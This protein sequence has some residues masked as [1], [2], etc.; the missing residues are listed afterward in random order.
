MTRKPG[1]LW[2]IDDHGVIQNDA[3]REYLQPPFSALIDNAVRAYVDHIGSDLDSIYVTGS[4][5]RGLAIEGQSDLNMFAVTDDNVDPDLVM[6]DWIKSAEADLI[7]KHP[8]VREVQLEIWPYYYAFTDPTRYAIG[9]FIL[10]THSVCVWGSDLALSLPDYGVTPGIANDD[11]VQIA[12]DIADTR[13][14]ITDDPNPV[15]VRYWSRTIAKNLLWAGFGLVQMEAGV[16]TRDMDRCYHYIAQHFP[17]HA[18]D[19]RRALDMVDNPSEDAAML[20]AYLDNVGEWLIA[21]ANKWLDQYNPSR[22]GA[23]LID[24]VEEID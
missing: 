1:R 21:Q 16:H 11:L 8:C 4:V 14:A 20:H 7:L 18:A 9:A 24:D 13:A 5:A 2:S 12:D 22:D 3:R 17:G 15:N 23:L 10:K 19:L 6:R